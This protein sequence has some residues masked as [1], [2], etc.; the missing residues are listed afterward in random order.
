MTWGLSWLLA[1]AILL[2]PPVWE[3]E[4]T[5]YNTGKVMR[6]GQP[7]DWSAPT[8]AVD[9]LVYEQFVTKTVTACT[10]YKCVQC[11]VTD[12]GYLGAG[13]IDLTPALFRLL[14]GGPDDNDGRLSVRVWVMQ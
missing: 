4:A 9:H 6:N 14:R 7:P 2:A 11:V 1:A 10:S 13:N 12:S 5:F 8:C 3:G